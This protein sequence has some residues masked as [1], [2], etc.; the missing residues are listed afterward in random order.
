ML[1]MRA[2]LKSAQRTRPR[3]QLLQA[4]LV[5]SSIPRLSWKIKNGLL[6]KGETMYMY[7]KRL[8]SELPS[9]AG[10]SQFCP[11]EPFLSYPSENACVR[12]PLMT[13]NLDWL[14]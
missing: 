1:G 12:R 11:P 6:Y 4:F 7:T 9:S 8:V 5:H 13:L 3:L 10:R 2:C 14:G